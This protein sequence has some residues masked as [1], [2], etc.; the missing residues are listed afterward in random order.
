MATQCVHPTS[1]STRA[2]L[3]RDSIFAVGAQPFSSLYKS[4]SWHTMRAT[5][6]EARAENLKTLRDR[7]ASV[8]STRRMVNGIKLVANAKIRRAQTAVI[9]ARPF[10][11][12]LVKTM[13]A[14]NTRMAG[15]DVHVPLVAVRQV[16]RVLIVVCT[17]DKSLC[18]GFNNLIIKQAEKRVAS[19]QAMDVQA[20]LLL[21]GRMGAL[22]FSRCSDRYT[23]AGTFNMG[24]LP[25]S[26]KSQAVADEIYSKF[27]SKEC[28]KV[29]LLYSKHVSMLVSL[30]TLQTI[31]PLTSAGVVRNIYGTIVDA[32]D[33]EAFN[34]T[35]NGGVASEIDNIGIVFEQDP[36]QILDALASLYL[37]SQVLRA[38]QD[39]VASEL[40]ARVRAMNT[41]SD[42][43]KEMVT[44]LSRVH[45]RS[46]RTKITGDLIELWASGSSV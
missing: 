14:V 26:T 45:N 4:R 41:A 16:K 15:K 43:A 17:S 13:Y 38:F 42:N 37:N 28:D 27:V 2:K 20:A 5:R 30:T 12:N 34:I 19:L 24:K 44:N 8:N 23:I 22:H 29:E 21:V 35:Q 1:G 11:E 36:A 31:L 7:I 46:R 6:L 9:G 33:D 10:S 39:S 3:C 25:T 32:E 40:S 18:G